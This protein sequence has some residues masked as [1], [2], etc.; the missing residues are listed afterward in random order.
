M[1]YSVYSK[2]REFVYFVVVPS[3][4]T[5]WSLLGHVITFDVTFENDLCTCWHLE[6]ISLGFNNIRFAAA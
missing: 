5:E 2:D 4:I 6:I 1:S 3:M